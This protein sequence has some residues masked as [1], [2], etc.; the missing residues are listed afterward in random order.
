MSQV[1]CNRFCSNYQGVTVWFSSSYLWTMQYG[2]ITNFY[3]I[4]KN[5]IFKKI[6]CWSTLGL[7]YNQRELLLNMFV[8]SFFTLVKKMKLCILTWT[9]WTQ[10]FLWFPQKQNA[11]TI[12]VHSIYNAHAIFCIINAVSWTA[13]LNSTFK[14][15][16]DKSY[17][18]SL[19]LK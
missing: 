16:L 11:S 19:T 2:K 12:E 4:S 3:A 17:N 18:A 13:R 14:M 5:M 6:I 1:R 8:R 10:V 15:T 9:W 7:H